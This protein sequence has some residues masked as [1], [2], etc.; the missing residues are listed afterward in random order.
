VFLCGLVL[1]L[2]ACGLLQTAAPLITHAAQPTSGPTSI[3]FVIPEDPPSF[4][5]I[6]SDSGY[7]ALAGYFGGWLDNILMRV[8]DALLTLPS[9]LV[10]ILLSATLREV[11][12][13][14][15]SRS[16][17]ASPLRIIT[18]RILPNAIGPIIVE[19]TLELGYAIILKNQA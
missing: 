8:T 19:A 5:T 16:L 11:D 17:G 15:A 2:S 3:T 10:L 4:N 13:V 14:T 9:L 7:D 12:F 6:I 18:T 1:G